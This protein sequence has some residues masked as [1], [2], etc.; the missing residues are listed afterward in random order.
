MP[1][2]EQS[3][4]PPPPEQSIDF[5]SKSSDLQSSFQK[6]RAQKL[7][8]AK[9]A[10]L[11]GKKASS[12]S[13]KP[14]V[15]SSSEK[16]L[17]REKWVTQLKSY[18]DVPYH[19]R[20]ADPETVQG[21]KDLQKG[22][23]LDCCGIIRQV[24]ADLETEMGW[25][26]GRGNQAYQY[27]LMAGIAQTGGSGFGQNKYRKKSCEEMQ[28][29][30]IIFYEADYLDE[31]KKPQAW[32]ITH[33]EIYLGPGEKSL[34]SRWKQRVAEHETFQLGTEERPSMLWKV[35]QNSGNRYLEAN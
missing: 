27:A 2:P 8:E 22:L 32:D 14:K 15:R 13:T 19:K 3:L 26:L 6:F 21:R 31:R 17:L 28:P 4:M 9:E 7:Q 10:R 1:S 29:G 23:F 34:G 25:K 35:K 18:L 5:F 24:S 33:V 16:E 20:Y 12:S 30:D 11:L